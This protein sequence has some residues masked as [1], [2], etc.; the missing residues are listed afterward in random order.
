[1]KKLG[2]FLTLGLVLS[3][4]NCSE[5]PSPLIPYDSEPEVQ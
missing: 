2:C 1:M 3:L 4:A 5:A